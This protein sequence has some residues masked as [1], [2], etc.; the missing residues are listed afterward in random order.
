MRKIIERIASEDSYDN[1]NFVVIKNKKF[2]SRE[3]TWS[4][5]SNK[6]ERNISTKTNSTAQVSD[7]SAKEDSESDDIDGDAPVRGIHPIQARSSHCI[8]DHL[9]SCLLYWQDAIYPTSYKA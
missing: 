6:L 5:S 1:T 7:N 9:D 8:P 2:M 3:R 4:N